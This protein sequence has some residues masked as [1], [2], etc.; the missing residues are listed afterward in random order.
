MKSAIDARETTANTAPIDEEA[1]T[2]A[3]MDAWKKRTRRCCLIISA[4]LALIIMVSMPFMLGDYHFR[5]TQ[6]ATQFTTN[7]RYNYFG[8]T[9]YKFTK[10]SGSDKELHI[11][12]SFMGEPV[13]IIGNGALSGNADVECVVVPE[14][15][16][17]IEADAFS[18]CPNLREVQLPD[19]LKYVDE[20]AFDNCPELRQRLPH[21]FIRRT[22]PASEE[23]F[24]LTNGAAYA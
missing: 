6:P 20:D 21:G 19:S 23:C 3:E 10:Y 2:R 15:V 5:K 13:V 24:L 14:G 1:R 9:G 12:Q 17:V 11:P 18:N 22:A 8:V 7:P 4:A 16:L